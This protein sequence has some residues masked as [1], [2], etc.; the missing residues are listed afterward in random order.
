VTDRLTTEIRRAVAEM[1]DAAPLPPEFPLPALQPAGPAHPKR[2][3]AMAMTLAFAV[4]VAAAVGI[5]NTRTNHPRV[6][7]GP[8]AQVRQSSTPAPTTPVAPTPS[9]VLPTKLPTTV[10]FLAG[11]QVYASTPGP[12]G[13]K[14]IILVGPSGQSARLTW[15]GSGDCNTLEPT[16]T[17]AQEAGQVAPAGQG[18]STM[19]TNP[20]AAPY[21]ASGNAGLLNW[22]VQSAGRVQLTTVGMGETGSRS[23]SR[24]V[25]SS[26]TAE[27]LSLTTPTGFVSGSPDAGG[28]QYTVKYGPVA[29]GASAP[30]VVVTISPAWTNNVS[31]LETFTGFSSPIMTIGGRPGFVVDTP[32]NMS[33][34]VLY[35]ANTIVS[36]QGTGISLNQVEVAAASLAPASS[37]LAPDVSADPSTCNILG[38]CG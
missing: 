28:F 20:D 11:G 33:A 22:C 5:W 38:L 37:A 29:T 17:V 12:G 2:T 32:G 18:Q 14:N 31:L 36:V 25:R 3:T 24:T 19:A 6:Q 26:P 10:K 1:V 9:F 27:G 30:T 21:R 34:T 8:S 16:T 13:V 7:V 35:D 15:S 4:V 23:L